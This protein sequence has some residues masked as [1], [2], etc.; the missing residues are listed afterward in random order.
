MVST[1]GTWSN[2][3]I[4]HFQGQNTY[5]GKQCHSAHYQG[6]EAYK[7]KRVLVIGGGNSGAQI[8]SELA[9]TVR[10][11]W[12]TR[13]APLFLPDDVDGR[14]L[15]ERA[16]ARITAN[17][18]D[19]PVGGIGDIVMIPTVK[20]AYDKGQ[21]NTVSMFERFTEHGVVWPDG[22]QEDIDAIIWCTGFKPELRHLAQLNVIESDDT[23]KVVH[24]QSIKEPRLWLFGYGDWASPGSATLIGSGRSAR[25]NVPKLVE[26]LKSTHPNIGRQ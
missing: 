15:F 24:G 17:G 1:T 5:L 18:A 26:F 14:V 16:T 3:K 7:G 19:T 20:N 8:V 4:P 22:S 21:L 9:Y 13:E 23:V 12:V 10:V 25:E 2:E 6:P 11:S